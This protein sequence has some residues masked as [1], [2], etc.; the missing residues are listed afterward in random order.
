MSVRFHSYKK[1]IFL[2]LSEFSSLGFRD[3]SCSAILSSALPCS[4]PPR[5]APQSPAPPRPIPPRIALPC[6]VPLLSSFVL[7]CL[8]EFT[9]FIF[10][11]HILFLFRFLFT[12]KRRPRS[13]WLSTVR[14]TAALMWVKSSH[15]KREKLWTL[16]ERD[17]STRS[18]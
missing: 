15:L 3:L 14:K 4:T 6:S 18:D 10:A 17:I 13:I 1:L 7:F 11:R 8:L 5:P 16:Q 12:V 9:V 2:L